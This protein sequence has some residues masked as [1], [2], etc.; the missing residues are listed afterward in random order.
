MSISGRF[1]AYWKAT[2]DELATYPIAAEAEPIPLRR[3]EFATMYGVKLTSIG[4]Y[5]IFA[6]LSIPDG[7]GP[8][9]TIYYTPRYQ[10]VVQP[11]PQG[12]AAGQR[13]TYITFAL[14]ARGYRNAD[15][16]YA[17]S[18]P[19]LLT[20]GIESAPA[21][22]FRGIA[23]DCVRGLDYLLTRP[24]VDPKRLVVVGN[25]MALIAASLHSGA[26]HAVAAPELFHDTLARA[27]ATS[28]YPLEEI[29]DCLRL[30][31]QRRDAVAH[32]LSCFELR[33]FAP[34][35]RA[36]TLLMAGAKGTAL[37]ARAL[38]SVADVI[39]GGVTVRESERSSYKDGLYA[40]R[41]I[42]EQCG[43][44]D[45]C[46]VLPEAWAKAASL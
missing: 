44:G 38:A 24:E 22:I 41:W 23:A 46:S 40:E 32:T 11:A 14:A 27:A 20:N 1:D 8:F 18:F 16:P 17:A 42:A 34:R 43:V 21:Y 9:P 12:T 5:R 3:T 28:A 36:K 45:L 6:Y 29:N 30:Y 13:G 2:L 15:K 10:S 35:L 31:P 33:F 26:T 19:G 4:P 37:D 7:K 25:D 39:R